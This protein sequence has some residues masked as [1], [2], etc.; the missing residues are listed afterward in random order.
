MLLIK[1]IIKESPIAGLGLFA[2]EFI[3]KG[4]VIW[5]L[6]PLIDKIIPVSETASFTAL[7]REFLEKYAYREGDNLILCSDNGRYFNHSSHPNTLDLI[8]ERG[9]VSVAKKDIE[10][11]EELVS[12][13][14][15]FDA[16]FK[17]YS[18]HFK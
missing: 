3:P 12:D 2:D 1:T 7:E 6:N 16:D 14:A 13:Y 18:H 10:A 17:T 9:S 11:G 5:K 4:T 15:S 8:D